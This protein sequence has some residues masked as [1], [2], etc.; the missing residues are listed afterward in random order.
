MAIAVVFPAAASTVVQHIESTA[1]RATRPANKMPQ[2]LIDAAQIKK[3]ESINPE[4]HVDFEPPDKIHTV[5]ETGLEGQGISPN[6]ASAPFRLFIP[7][8]R[9][10]QLI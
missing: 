7:K 8:N 6:T 1:R 2:F 4:K 10:E 3:E 5:K 9:S